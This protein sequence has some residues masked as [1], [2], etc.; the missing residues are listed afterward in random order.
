MTSIATQMKINNVQRNAEN[1]YKCQDEGLEV[2]KI[3]SYTI[4]RRGTK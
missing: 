4:T 1:Q 3:I 2:E